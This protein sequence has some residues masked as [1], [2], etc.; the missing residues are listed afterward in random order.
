MADL[1]PNPAPL[2]ELIWALYRQQ[3]LRVCAVYLLTYGRGVHWLQQEMLAP[4]AALDQLQAV[5]DPAILPREAIHL[6]QVMVDGEPSEDELLPGHAAAWSAARW[7]LCGEAIA[8]AGA[9]PVIFGLIGGR[10]R[11]QTAV[12]PAMFPLLARPQDRCLDVRVSDPRVEGGTGFF[13]PEQP[14]Q[15]VRS[16]TGGGSIEA[17]SVA[18]WLIEVPLPR[19]RAL[20][21]EKAL[22]D[23][24]SALHAS[25][26]AVEAAQLPRLRLD[27]MA[28]RAWVNDAPMP[29]SPSQLVWYATLA[30]ARQRGEG[31][32]AVSDRSALT[33]VF[34]RIDERTSWD[35]KLQTSLI[36][37]KMRRGHANKL[38]TEDL[39][40]LR[41]RTI[42][43]VQR[44]S[45]PLPQ[46]HLLIPQKQAWGKGGKVSY[47][48][49]P[50]PGSQVEIHWPA[51]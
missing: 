19:L 49:L 10:R 30:E 48:R 40:P 31:W 42:R 8:A 6:R 4:G 2:I 22:S 39:G 1:G 15:R 29:L 20:L 3:S 46:G 47:Q 34:L 12:L 36:F 25:Q 13:F 5:V 23:W 41:A 27:M 18:V 24:S 35:E 51:P 38:D 17:R 50:L 33:A 43:M 16:N 26:E 37:E 28:G 9:L 45:D 32:V 44:F 11:T 21:P 14:Q 7:R